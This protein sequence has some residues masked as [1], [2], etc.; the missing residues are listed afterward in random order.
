MSDKKYRLRDIPKG[1]RLAHFLNYYKLRTFF[2]LVFAVMVGYTLYGIFKPRPDLQVM[3]LSDRYSLECEFQLRKTLEGLNWD[4]DG[5][6]NSGGAMLTYIDFDRE[7]QALSYEVKTELTVLVAGQEYSFFLV[8]ELARD[9]MEENELLAT[10]EEAGISG[11]GAE[12]YLAV[13]VKQMEAFSP[14]PLEQ[15]S[16]NCLCVTP[17]PFEESKLPEYRRQTRV[18]REFLAAQGITAPLP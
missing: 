11:P 16:H 8:N 4:T 6:G 1:E 15:M 12:R 7:Y 2:L 18:L 10:W 14:P 3:W 9:W 5:D 17:P 13:P